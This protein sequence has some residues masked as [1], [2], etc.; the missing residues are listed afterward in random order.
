TPPPRQVEFRIKLV[1]GAAPITHSPYSLAPSKM[2]ELSEQLKELLEK[3][4]IRPSLSP[5]GA[6]VRACTQRLICDQDII[7]SAFEKR[8]DQSQPFKIGMVTLSSK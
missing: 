6:L 2:K 7:N 5:W 8:I 1:P 3:G 4:F